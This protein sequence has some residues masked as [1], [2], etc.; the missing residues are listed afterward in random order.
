MFIAYSSDSLLSS[1]FAIVPSNCMIKLFPS[2]YIYIFLRHL[3]HAL[4]S[5]H[6]NLI[7]HP[8]LPTF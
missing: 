2:V 4:S 7:S 8:D 5:L 3:A 1:L 6:M